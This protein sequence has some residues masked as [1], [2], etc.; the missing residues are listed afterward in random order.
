MLVALEGRNLC[1]D[2]YPIFGGLGGFHLGCGSF[3]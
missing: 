3:G 2:M 1:I